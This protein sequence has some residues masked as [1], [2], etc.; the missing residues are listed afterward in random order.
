[1]APVQ[2]GASVAATGLG[3]RYIGSGD[4]QHVYAFSGQ[5]SVD[6]S[7][8]SLIEATTGSG[9]IV[10][11]VQF[12]YGAIDDASD[13]EY[14]IL[15]NDIRVFIYTVTGAHQS[16]ASEPD[17]FINILVPPFTKF[18]LAARRRTGSSPQNQFVALVGRVYGAK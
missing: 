4:I 10:G 5:V 7:Q 18:V 15:L 2:P 8:V 9:Y 1:M 11:K 12:N 3:L 14:L 17:N 13:F 16:T 6:D